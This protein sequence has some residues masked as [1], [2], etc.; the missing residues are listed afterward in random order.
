MLRIAERGFDKTH[1]DNVMLRKLG[2]SHSNH[3]SIVQFNFFV[4]SV[5]RTSKSS[6][7][8]EVLLPAIGCLVS[9][10]LGEHRDRERIHVGTS[11]EVK[12][13][14]V[15]HNGQNPDPGIRTGLELEYGQELGLGQRT[16][17]N[18]HLEQH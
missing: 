1:K 4:V 7:H 13:N 3:N 6:Q 5:E 10:R 17:L 12:V 8:G 16:S 18:L 9:Q 11:S 15:R 14:D 2:W